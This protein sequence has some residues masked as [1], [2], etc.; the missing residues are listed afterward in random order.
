MCVGFLYSKV[1]T[2]Y[3]FNLGLGELLT[4]LDTLD[5]L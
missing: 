5:S 2:K 4:S 1:G 3:L